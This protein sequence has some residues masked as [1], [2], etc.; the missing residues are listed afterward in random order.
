MLNPNVDLKTIDGFGKEWQSFNQSSLDEGQLLSLFQKYFRHFPWQK[1]SVATAVGADF[2]CGSGRWAKFVAPRVRHLHLIDASSQALDVAKK[3][4]GTNPKFSYHSSSIEEADIA[5]GSLD[6]AYSLG[7]LHH[8]PDTQKAISDIARFLKPGAPFLIYLYYS[9]D[10]RPVWFKALWSVTDLAR[11]LICRFPYLLRL[12]TTQLLAAV[13]YYPLA[14]MAAA[15]SAVHIM[16]AS[17]PLAFYRDQPFY[18]MRNDALDRFGTRL[19]KRYSKAEITEMLEVSGFEKTSFSDQ[20]PYWC[21]V[22]Y[23]KN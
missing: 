17:W 20:A 18:V 23:K 2:G 11:K 10:Q 9:F 4:L 12:L 8:L 5:S 13:I 1:I 7:V 15:M 22:A 19:E 21:A 14:R 6:F 3:M 16:P